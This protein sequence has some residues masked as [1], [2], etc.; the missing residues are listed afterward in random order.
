MICATHNLLKVW[1]KTA[2]QRN[3]RA[4]FK[5]GRPLS[6]GCGD[7]E[8]PAVMR[9]PRTH[10]DRLFIHRDEIGIWLIDGQTA[11]FRH[12]IPFLLEKIYTVR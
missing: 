7:D 8:R 2:W 6:R 5:I 12:G 10:F 11:K 4:V 1:R 3:T 9:P